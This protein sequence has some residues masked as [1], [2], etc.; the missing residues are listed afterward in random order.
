MPDLDDIAQ[1]SRSPETRSVLD[2]LEASGKVASAVDGFRLAI[3]VAIA[4]GCT[5]NVDPVRRQPRGNWIAASGLDTG[6]SAIK[7]VVRELFP[8][9][10]AT[11]YRAIEDLGEQGAKLLREKMVGDEID[12]ESLIESV[13]RV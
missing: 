5:P 7:T 10:R 2:E 6:D 4:F 12:L 13:E 3:S 11:P 9:V 1:I 8:D